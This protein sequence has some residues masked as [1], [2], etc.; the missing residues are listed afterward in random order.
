M[1]VMEI[2]CEK[3]AFD[4]YEAGQTCLVELSVTE[5]WDNIVREIG[6]GRDEFER[7]RNKEYI[8]PLGDKVKW[9]NKITNEKGKYKCYFTVNNKT[10]YINYPK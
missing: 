2:L 3:L 7:L 1:N 9:N 6:A 4:L 5:K 8:T 10:I